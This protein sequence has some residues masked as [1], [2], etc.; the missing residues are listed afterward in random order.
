M[1]S[2]SVK[3]RILEKCLDLERFSKELSQILPKTVGEYQKS[4]LVIKSTV[5][6]RLQLISDTELDMLSI[7][8]KELNL[9][10]VGE[11][12]SLLSMFSNILK[13]NV[14]EK[15]KRLRDMRNKLIHEYKSDLFDEEVFKIATENLDEKDTISEIKH[16]VNSKMV[17]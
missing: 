15:I 14:I 12:F 10:V 5:E 4:D 11:D 13:N 17:D 7:L 6:R 9:K 2:E 16:I 1:N 3:N 8:Y